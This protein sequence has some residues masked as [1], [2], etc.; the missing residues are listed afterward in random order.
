MSKEE[1]DSEV[2]DTVQD[3]P[4][5]NNND[6]DDDDDPRAAFTRLNT[7]R[8]L[9]LTSVG[10]SQASSMLASE[11]TLRSIDDDEKAKIHPS[12]M[13]DD[14]AVQVT[15]LN[16]PSHPSSE[17]TIQDQRQKTEQ[18]QTNRARRNPNSRVSLSADQV[19]A[20]SNNQPASGSTHNTSGRNTKT[21]RSAA[22]VP[23]AS[24]IDI[25][26]DMDK[27]KETPSAASEAVSSQPN[28]RA[29][30]SDDALGRGSSA[31]VR[32]PGAYQVDGRTPSQG[33]EPAPAS[34][35]TPS[36]RR[37]K[38]EQSVVMASAIDKEALKEELRQELLA[39][40]AAAHVVMAVPAGTDDDNRDSMN[41]QTQQSRSSSRSSIANTNRKW[42]IMLA[43]MVLLVGGAVGVAFIVRQNNSNSNNN[44]NND[45]NS[46]NSDG[47][48]SGSGGSGGG[49]NGGRGNRN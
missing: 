43:M 31:P 8:I 1:D 17:Q 3:L 27:Q 40:Q 24:A 32:S 29:A 41:S 48:N 21:K 36:E 6:D 42:W 22:T 38:G 46:P 19:L 11:S 18:Q 20:L 47:G 44:N 23:G 26:S 30:S 34:P 7:D 12:K 33:A 2:S 9:Q 14:D 28:G 4:T 15:K 13:D 5:P 10:T 35:T 16:P 37:S 25:A 45:D 39:E 49:G